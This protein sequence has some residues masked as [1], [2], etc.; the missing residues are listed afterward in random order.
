MT[1]NVEKR[2]QVPY[3]VERMV[4]MAS[5]LDTVRLNILSESLFFGAHWLNVEFSSYFQPKFHQARVKSLM[6]T[7]DASMKAKIPDDILATIRE[8]VVDR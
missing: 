3:N 1:V 7:F 8:V 5:G 6:T 2:F 4:L